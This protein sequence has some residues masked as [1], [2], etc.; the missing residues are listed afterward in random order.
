MK[1]YM[2][3]K[4]KNIILGWLGIDELVVYQK[5]E[6]K[7][8]KRSINRLAELHSKLYTT[9]EKEKTI[10][11]P[12]FNIK[13]IKEMESSLK[14][15]HNEF[16][17]AMDGRLKDLEKEIEKAIN[18]H[19]HDTRYYTK[20]EMDVIINKVNEFDS[21]ISEIKDLVLKVLAK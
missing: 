2:S 6:Y 19:K 17:W 7:N 21:R 20:T 16:V 13:D 5:K 11:K 8:I 9:F 4:L 1:G 3:N 18:I 10:W 12:D 15:N 14:R